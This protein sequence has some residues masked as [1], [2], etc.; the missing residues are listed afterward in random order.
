MVDF[1][2]WLL[3]VEHD[4]NPADYDALFDKELEQLLPRIRDSAEQA[5]LRGLI[6]FNH[7]QFFFSFSM[8]SRSRSAWA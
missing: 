7:G 6:E 5:R 4:L 2:L 3:L 8:S 1:R